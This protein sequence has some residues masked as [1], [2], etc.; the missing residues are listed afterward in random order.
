MNNGG[1]QETLCQL[2][3]G[4]EF[5]N[6]VVVNRAPG[7]SAECG[8]ATADTGILEYRGQRLAVHGRALTLVQCIVAHQQRINATAPSAGQLWLSWKGDGPRSITGDIKA[9]L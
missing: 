4:P 2:S 7:Q 9:P 8:A 5:G 1:A 6:P 3:L